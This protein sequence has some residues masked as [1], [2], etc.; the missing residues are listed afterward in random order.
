MEENTRLT[1]LIQEGDEAKNRVGGDV[2][3]VD[4]G[5]SEDLTDAHDPSRQSSDAG[6]GE[7]TFSMAA[8]QDVKG[9]DNTV[10]AAGEG[11]EKK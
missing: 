4:E 8:E 5:P 9:E 6:E 3:K 7:A 1:A 2:E 11:D 10:K